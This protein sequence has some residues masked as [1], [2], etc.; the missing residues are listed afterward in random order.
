MISKVTLR[1]TAGLGDRSDSLAAVISSH[2]LLLTK[3]HLPQRSST[4]AMTK[5]A[6]C[7]KLIKRAWGRELPQPV[8]IPVTSELGTRLLT[9]A[10]KAPTCSL[11]LPLDIQSICGQQRR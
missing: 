1:D 9:Y 8:V 3:V 4:F 6:D 11:R 2:L 7:S 10:G 5:M